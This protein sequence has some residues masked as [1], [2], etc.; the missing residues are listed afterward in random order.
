MLT[1]HISY[2]VFLHVYEFVLQI[3]GFSFLIEKRIKNPFE[4]IISPQKYKSKIDQ[5][6]AYRVLTYY[7]KIM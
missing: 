3:F 4:T 1:G 2:D 7:T 5:L 6:M